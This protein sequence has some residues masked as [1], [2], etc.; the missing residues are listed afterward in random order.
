MKS[1]SSF[2]KKVFN[3]L[4]E[5]FLVN[6]EPVIL[7]LRNKKELDALINAVSDASQWT[8]HNYNE[9]IDNAKIIES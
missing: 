1:K 5:F 2:F 9:I 3:R 4:K 7:I 6:E 8:G